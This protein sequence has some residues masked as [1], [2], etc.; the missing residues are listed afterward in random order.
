MEVTIKKDGWAGGGLRFVKIM[1]GIGDDHVLKVSGKT[2]NVAIGL[3]LP[4]ATSMTFYCSKRLD[5]TVDLKRS[6]TE[7]GVRAICRRV[8]AFPLNLKF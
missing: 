5:V 2:L 7:S 3:G 8:S 6:E 4:S 1:P